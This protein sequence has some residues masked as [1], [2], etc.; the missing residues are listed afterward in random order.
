MKLRVQTCSH[1]SL[2]AIYRLGLLLAFGS[3]PAIIRV[4]CN[5]TGLSISDS[6]DHVMLEFRFPADEMTF[7]GNWALTSARVPFRCIART[8]SLC[9]LWLPRPTIGP[10]A[11]F[12]LNLYKEIARTS[13]V[14]SN[15]PWDCPRM[16]RMQLYFFLNEDSFLHF[17]WASSAGLGEI[18]CLANLKAY[19]EL[20]GRYYREITTE[21]EIPFSHSHSLNY[22]IQR[23]RRKNSRT[24]WDVPSV[25][26][27]RNSAPPVL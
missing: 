23:I 26:D 15:A 20:N 10:D 11:R 6:Q 24:L 17:S 14:E 21:R 18:Q 7:S 25:R 9:A 16:I 12:L 19:I 22:P 8:S 4:K 3:F 5:S 27:N 1:S 13:N 2:N